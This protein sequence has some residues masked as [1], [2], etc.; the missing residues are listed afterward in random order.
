[1]EDKDMRQKSRLRR[2]TPILAVVAAL[3]L[4]PAVSYA[5][6]GKVLNGDTNQMEAVADAKFWADTI[7]T[8]IT[9]MLVFFMQAGFAMVEGGFTRAKN[10]SNIMM[11]NLLDFCMGSL[12]FWAVG[13]GIMF[14]NGNGFMGMTGFMVAPGTGGLYE[15]LA[16]T[17]VPTLCAWFF[18]LV[19]AATAAT[20]VS[21]AMAERTKFSGYLVYSFII[22][23]VFYPIVGHW[24]WGGGWLANMGMLDFAGSTV[25]HS[26]GGWFALAGAIVLGPR[27]GKYAKDGKPLALVGHNLP[28]ATLGTFILWF[29]WFG[30]NPGSTMGADVATMS[31]TAA[32]TNLAAAAGAIGAM[33]TAWA[34]LGKPELGMTL[35]GALAGL[36]A[37]TCSC[38]FVAPWAAIVFFGFVPG[39]VVVLAV[40]M[41][42]RV[43][44]DDPVGAVSVHGVCGALGTILLGLFH[45]DQGLLYGGGTSFL[46]TQVIGVVSVAAFC[47]VS[48]LIL[49]KV[50]SLTIGLR[51][52]P[53]EELEGLDIGEHGNVAYP[54]FRL[55]VFGDSTS[56]TA[57]KSAH[58]PSMVHQPAMAGR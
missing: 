45:T 34:L 1:M 58:Q 2:L 39:A 27:I 36:V 11:K 47:V 8:I 57:A 15:S 6:D 3:L 53:E 5:L 38:A 41:F 30:F 29:G 9:A 50:I 42:D 25:V 22:S 21:G 20:I 24:I 26:V 55:P 32:N 17:S 14:G 56:P 4:I 54:E 13:F 16:W 19:F 37:I 35:N 44:I 33:I 51:V 18:Q 10:T 43:G 31:I 12:A 52:T 46:F 7:W 48:G 49:F 23:L 40:M 28:M